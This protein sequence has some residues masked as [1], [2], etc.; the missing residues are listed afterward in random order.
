M[1]WLCVHFA[2][3]EHLNGKIKFELVLEWNKNKGRRSRKAWRLSWICFIHHECQS[4]HRHIHS[5]QEWNLIRIWIR[6]CVSIQQ[7]Q[8][9][10]TGK[11]KGIDEKK[12]VHS[13]RDDIKELTR[14]EL[15]DRWH[16]TKADRSLWAVKREGCDEATGVFSL[17]STWN[18]CDILFCLRYNRFPR[19][20]DRI[21]K[22][23]AEEKSTKLNAKQKLF[24]F[25]VFACVWFRFM[26]RSDSH[27]KLDICV[28]VC[29]SLSVWKASKMVQTVLRSITSTRT[30]Q[31]QQ[32][33]KVM[34]TFAILWL[35]I[36]PYDCENPLNVFHR[37]FAEHQHDLSS[38]RFHRFES[39]ANIKYAR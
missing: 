36:N 13:T 25:G 19:V 12:S 34:Q 23:L 4:E 33:E 26:Y 14:V 24:D 18:K 39:N 17:C 3:S 2:Q 15:F 11:M 7:R 28:R 20:K 10:H 30:N 37:A 32:Q 31:Q 22:K 35:K 9:R 29:V 21:K 8:L 1:K 5:S 16:L 27:W 6:V 38:L